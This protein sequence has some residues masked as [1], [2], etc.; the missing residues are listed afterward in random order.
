MPVHSAGGAH[1]GMPYSESPD[2]VRNFSAMALKSRIFVLRNG[3]S[4]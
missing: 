1:G 4:E 3:G 2:A